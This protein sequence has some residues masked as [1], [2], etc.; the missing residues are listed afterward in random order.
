MSP[1]NDPWRLKRLP[2]IT[3]EKFTQKK[4]LSVGPSF[5][6]YICLSIGVVV[7]TACWEM[8][9]EQS[10]NPQII[11]MQQWRLL[12]ENLWSHFCNRTVQ[13]S[14]QEI[15]QFGI[16]TNVN[17]T[18]N[19]HCGVSLSEEPLIKSYPV[20]HLEELQLTNSNFSLVCWLQL[21]K[22]RHSV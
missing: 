4:S 6:T 20:I 2:W 12:L 7:V 18:N 15:W 19:N 1:M 10:W 13:S 5:T 8:S 21:E 16:W 9:I 3:H 17:P 14:A 11:I 22:F